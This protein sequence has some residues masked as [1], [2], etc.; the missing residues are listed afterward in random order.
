MEP[1]PGIAF[2]HEFEWVCKEPALVIWND[3][4]RSEISSLGLPCP[5]GKPTLLTLWVGKNAAKEAYLMLHLRISIRVSKRRKILDHYLLPSSG[6]RMTASTSVVHLKDASEDVR[7]CL[8]E[9]YGK[10]STQKCLRIPFVQPK[11]GRVLMPVSP[12]KAPCLGG[13]ALHLMTLLH[14]LSR[15]NSFEVFVGHSSYAQHALANIEGVLTDSTNIDLL[16]SFGGKGGVFDDWRR[17]GFEQPGFLKAQD[18]PSRHHTEGNHVNID[19]SSHEACS[20]DDQFIRN[21]PVILPP[22]YSLPQNAE[23]PTTP[24]TRVVN[25]N[26]D[27][28]NEA[29]CLKRS[30]ASIAH[31]DDSPPT[32]SARSQQI[33]CSP[34][35]NDTSYVT[36]DIEKLS[37][38]E[39]TGYSPTIANTPSTVQ[40]THLLSAGHFTPNDTKTIQIEADDS[41][42]GHLLSARRNTSPSIVSTPGRSDT[43]S[44]KPTIFTNRDAPPKYTTNTEEM[45]LQ[46]QT[47]AK[48]ASSFMSSSASLDMISPNKSTMRS[49]SKELHTLVSAKVPLLTEQ[50]LQRLINDLLESLDYSQ[51]AAE[52]GLQETLDDLK[53]ELQLEK[54]KSIEDIDD[55]AEHILTD[56]KCQMEDL[57]SG[58][59]VS[60]E[61]VLQRTGEQ[62][63]QTLKAFLIVLAKAVATGKLDDDDPPAST[64]NI[65][66]TQ[67]RDQ[68]LSAAPDLQTLNVISS[69]MADSPAVAATKLFLLEFRD[70]CMSAKVKVLD[71]LASQNTAEIF[72]T[73]DKELREAWV[74]SW[75]GQV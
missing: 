59:L 74:A 28:I 66:T 40:D 32:K 64:N 16:Q 22:P 55:H 19:T 51:K 35:F 10:F 39:Q 70:L 61:D 23:L 43:L 45:S 1:P 4:G 2:A 47:S 54:D 52:L 15:A 12:E 60:F 13:T 72:L 49:L 56:V 27:L 42:T 75:T 38:P 69:G 17:L 58:H 33:S 30:Y 67:P 7:Q 37:S 71:K 26:L 31:E 6:A 9:A 46:N 5:T 14:S 3:P 65:K 50:A 62:L 29:I 73:V 24:K 53:V 20:L 11:S 44:I 41:F 18:S 34:N 21:Q 36:H 25:E 8:E 68:L 57:A 63:K 48:V